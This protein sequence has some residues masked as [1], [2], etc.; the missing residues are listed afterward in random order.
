MRKRVSVAREVWPG[1][2]SNYIRHLPDVL[3]DGPLVVVL[4]CRVSSGKQV[5]TGNLDEAVA[6]AL[7]Q[8]QD[9][10]INPIAVVKGSE[11]SNVFEY[12]PIL[13]RALELAR[14]NHAILVAPSRDRLIRSRLFGR[15]ESMKMEPP[16]IVEYEELLRI[17]GT[18]PLA[19]ILHPDERA[20]R[21]SQTKRG[22]QAKG[23][24]G[25]R[26]TKRNY[27]P[28]LANDAINRSKTWWLTR[29]GFS[30][31]E[32]AEMTG[33]SKSTI[34]G[35]VEEL[36]DHVLAVRIGLQSGQEDCQKPGG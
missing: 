18:V 11:T 23:K 17:A 16:A 24:K 14:V 1:K 5:Q 26:P 10:G 31:G 13:E 20:V 33:R 9:F 27:K 19:T 35:W 2:A 28:R 29:V 22:Q 3:G 30:I 25:G 8:L 15:G 21:S 7:R 4:M 36:K 32:I 12:R 6:D 34:Q